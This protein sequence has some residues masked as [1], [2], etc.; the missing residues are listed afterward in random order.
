VVLEAFNPT[1]FEASLVYRVPGQRGAIEK[2]PVPKNKKMK[3]KAK[4]DKTHEAKANGG[5]K[6]IP[7][8]WMPQNHGPKISSKGLEIVLLFF[9]TL[10]DDN[11]QAKR[12]NR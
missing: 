9:L 4:Q 11:I 7:V 1:S 2:N 10:M 6:K 8:R 12:K 5:Y 3:Q